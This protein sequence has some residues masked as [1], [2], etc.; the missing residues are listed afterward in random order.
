ME[1]YSVIKV[2]IYSDIEKKIKRA[3]K[4]YGLNEKK[5]EKEIR[6]IDKLRE[7]HYKHYTWQDWKNFSNYDICIN[8]DYYGVEKTAEMICKMID[9]KLYFK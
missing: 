3:K 9:E 6:R 2:F 1:Y 5:A 4:Y 8:S 7:E